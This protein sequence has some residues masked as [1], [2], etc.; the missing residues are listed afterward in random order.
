MILYHSEYDSACDFF[1][2][3]VT[4]NLY[5]LRYSTSK[6]VVPLQKYNNLQLE[7]LSVVPINSLKRQ[8]YLLF[9]LLISVYTKNK[10]ELN[11]S[12]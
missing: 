8:K 6:Y 2:R 3:M 11:N 10:T 12:F 4:D 7:H 5:I 9:E 1:L